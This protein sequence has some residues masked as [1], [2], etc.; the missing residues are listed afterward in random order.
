MSEV[1]EAAQESTRG[2]ILSAATEIF[3]AKGYLRTTVREICARAK[4]NLALV[5][6]HFESKENLYV[7]VVEQMFEQGPKRLMGLAD[8]VRDEASWRAAIRKWIK[9]SIE[10]VTAE[11]PPLSYLS[12]FIAQAPEAPEKVKEDLFQRHHLP[13]RLD[14]NR[15]LRM[16]LPE[17]ISERDA[18]LQISLWC[19][20]IESVCMSHAMARPNWV[21]NFCPAGVTHEEWIAA[22]LDW[23]CNLVF[24]LLRYRAPE[25]PV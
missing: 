19:S 20:V 15:L 17:D 9:T 11:E 5:N 1:S 6:Y 2:R 21:D 7:A 13:L 25:K 4:V 22:E 3:A 18:E 14:L 12:A 23:M 16:G 24:S 10:T 8:S